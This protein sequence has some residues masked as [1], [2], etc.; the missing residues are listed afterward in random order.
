MGGLDAKRTATLRH[1][2]ELQQFE[3]QYRSRLTAYIESQLRDHA[4][5]EKAALPAGRD[6]DTA[7]EI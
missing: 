7:L 1:I 3:R 2:E 4:G 5:G 6:G